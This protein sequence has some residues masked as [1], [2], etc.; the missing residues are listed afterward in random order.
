METKREGSAEGL[1]REKK[2]YG[3]NW[4]YQSLMIVTGIMEKSLDCIKVHATD[5]ELKGREPEWAKPQLSVG[6]K[7]LQKCIKNG[8]PVRNMRYFG[9]TEFFSLFWNT[10]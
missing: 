9:F 10:F 4:V 3:K 5:L 7:L 8:Y 2:E 6:K 1:E